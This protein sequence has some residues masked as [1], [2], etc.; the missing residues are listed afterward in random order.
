MAENNDEKSMMEWQKLMP[1]AYSELA[2][3]KTM[4]FTKSFLFTLETN[5][6]KQMMIME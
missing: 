2:I 1:V 3:S 5:D 4:L 6:E